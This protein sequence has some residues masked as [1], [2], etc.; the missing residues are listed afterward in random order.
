MNFHHRGCIG[1]FIQGQPEYMTSTQTMPTTLPPIIMEVEN[2]P[3]VKEHSLGG[4][5]SPLP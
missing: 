2:G 3:I 1:L 4:T 5:H